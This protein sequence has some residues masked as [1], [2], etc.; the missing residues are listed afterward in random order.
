VY[1]LISNHQLVVP[2]LANSATALQGLQAACTPV[3]VLDPG[4]SELKE[5][6]IIVVAVVS[7]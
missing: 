6:S 7:V 3:H 4:S 5:V 1:Y 2:I